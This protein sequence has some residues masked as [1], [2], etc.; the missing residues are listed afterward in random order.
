[1]NKTYAVE[2]KAV[3]AKKTDSLLYKF[4]VIFI[5]FAVLSVL[6]CGI[7]TYYLQ[8]KRYKTQVEEKVRG[9]AEYLQVLIRA[10]DV[11]FLYYQNY[12]IEHKDDIYIPYDYD[13][14]YLPAKEKFDKLFSEQY[15]GKT[16]GLN[17]SFD[18]LSEEV[19]NAFAV[20][21]HEYWL[22]VFESATDAFDV[23]YTYYIVPSEEPEYMYY[24]ID[25]IREEKPIGDTSYIELGLYIHEDPKMYP[26][27]WD[28]WE[29]GKALHTYDIFDNQY[30]HTYGFYYPLYIEGQKQGLICV[31]VEIDA[32]NKEI[33]RSSLFLILGIAFI[34]FIG[35]TVLLL[36]IQK[37]YIAR[38]KKLDGSI[39]DYAESKN[40]SIAN[41]I[42]YD[43]NASD[44]ISSLAKQTS[45]MIRELD[46]YMK[47]LFNTTKELSETRQQA[48]DLQ[49][50]ANRDSLTGIRNKT[51]YDE[52]I[53]NLE[54]E[55][56]VGADKFGICMI[57]LNYL[58][59]INDEYGHDKGNYA[60]NKLCKIVCNIFK[61]SPVFRIGGDEFAVILKNTDY[62]A[63]NELTGIFN[64]EIEKLSSDES[65]EPWERTSAAIG[66][67]LF[68]PGKD[69]TVNDVFKRADE[70]MY[71]RK[72]DM[73][74][75]RE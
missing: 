67:A 29:E 39:K 41:V 25:S 10:D 33:L 40:P 57:D 54:W 61:H 64:E 31:D 17:I 59:K 45:A 71:Q 16:I 23:K 7:A 18:E 13:G 32:V 58:K 22:Y 69:F 6:S 50:L 51:A 47:S 24:V 36:I 42:A 63:I 27:M 2:N 12:L 75:F 73:K 53:K 65:L 72:H 8:T 15:P 9:I 34:L 46:T 35:V 28:T 4:G 70:N 3:A 21:T 1:M 66:V 38:I 14:N 48:K 62:D 55:V 19:K 43:E 11:D 68:D 26:V 74:A 30:G 44:E 20:Y 37:K 52:E 60:I 56:A 49:A 5:V